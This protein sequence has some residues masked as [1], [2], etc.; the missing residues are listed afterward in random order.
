MEPTWNQ[1]GTKENQWNQTGTRVEPTFGHGSPHEFTSNN[2]RVKVDSM[3]SS[4]P[5]STAIKDHPDLKLSARFVGI[6]FEEVGIGQMLSISLEI[7]CY[8]VT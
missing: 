2:R 3:N 7:K 1:N 8:F 6:R 5:T 4:T